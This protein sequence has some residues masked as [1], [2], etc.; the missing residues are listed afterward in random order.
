MINSIHLVAH[1]NK[2]YVPGKAMTVHL[3]NKLYNTAQW[4]ALG[5][6]DKGT[7]VQNPSLISLLSDIP[8]CFV[9]V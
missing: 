4:L 6:I 9:Y 1:D 2:I 8:A 5:W 3:C 7:S